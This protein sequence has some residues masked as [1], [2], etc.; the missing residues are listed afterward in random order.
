MGDKGES[1]DG[2]VMEQDSESL[3]WIPGS[4]ELPPSIGARASP[5]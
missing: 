4:G 3:S 1:V 5:F 2:G